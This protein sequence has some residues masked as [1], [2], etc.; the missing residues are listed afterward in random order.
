M[1]IL[2]AGANENWTQ[3]FEELYAMRA[4]EKDETAL[5]ILRKVEIE[6]QRCHVK[7]ADPKY[8]KMASTVV[9]AINSSY[10]AREIAD[11]MSD[12][13]QQEMNISGEGSISL[14][15]L[16]TT[17]AAQSDKNIDKLQ[18]TL[19]RIAKEKIDLEKKYKAIIAWGTIVGLL[20]VIWCL[21]R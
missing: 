20:I 19:Q 4:R 5:A 9:K 16:G 21:N 2:N 11:K 3:A 10:N 12:I 1:D 6:L 17:H 13:L 18:K 14:L 8:R 7:I 15:Q